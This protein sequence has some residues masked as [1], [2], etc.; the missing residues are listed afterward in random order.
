MGLMRAEIDSAAR[1]WELFGAVSLLLAAG[2]WK[3]FSNGPPRI[4]ERLNISVE[5]FLSICRA[6]DSNI[7]WK[8]QLAQERRPNSPGETTH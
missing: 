8:L 4:G 1:T 3:A 6:A 5:A 2:V 7:P